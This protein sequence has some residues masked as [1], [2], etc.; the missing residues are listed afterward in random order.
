[1]RK[2]FYALS[3]SMLVLAIAAPVNTLAGGPVKGLP[4]GGVSQPASEAKKEFVP[5]QTKTYSAH[6]FTGPL[7]RV[8]SSGP[9]MAPAYSGADMPVI[10]GNVTF[11]SDEAFTTGAMYKVPMTLGGNFEYVGG[12]D[13]YANRGGV[14]VGDRYMAHTG[15]TNS[16]GALTTMYIRKL[17]TT[18]WDQKAKNSSVKVG[19]MATDLALDPTTDKVYG[20]FYND[21]QD[22]YVLGRMD[23]SAYKRI[24]IAELQRGWNAC[25]FDAQGQLYAIDMSGMLMKVDKETGDITNVGSTGVTPKYLTSACIDPVSGR[26]FWSV[27]PAD[28]SGRLY[29]V[30]LATGAATLL[31]RF[32]GDEDVVGMYIPTP[33][34]QDKAPARVDNLKAEFVN[35]ALTGNITFDAPTTA[36]DGS[37]L[38]GELTYT[39]LN[40][41]SKI[42]EGTTTCGAPTSVPVTIE[43]AA[44]CEFYVTVANAVGSSPKSRVLMYVGKDKPVKPEVSAV[45]ADG[46]F[47]VSWNPVTEGVN[48]GYMNADAVTYKV[49]R[50]PDKTVVA[51]ATAETSLIDEVAASDA[52]YIPYYYTVT[53][54]SEGV[55]SD[56]GQSNSI[57]LGQMVPPYSETFPNA[58]A[59]STFTIIDGNND[60]KVWTYNLGKA[61]I[62]ENATLNM[63][64]WLITPPI[65]LEK[66]KIYKFSM[67]LTTA[68]SYTECFEV[69]YGKGNTVADMT[70]VL[71]E[72]QEINAGDGRKFSAYVKADT[73]GLYYIGIHGMTK[74]NQFYIDVDNLMLEEGTTALIPEAPTKL[75]VAP[76]QNGALVADIT[77]NAPAKNLLGN[78]IE[79]LDKVEILR[80]GTVIDTKNQPAAGA[81]VSF[82][83]E[84]APAGKHIYAVVGY[85]EH[86]RGWEA[87]D[88]AYVGINVPAAATKVTAKETANVGEVTVT[89]QT[90]TT[91]VD[92]FAINP[93]LIKYD[94]VSVCGETTA[95]VA[96][97]LTANTYTYRVVDADTPQQFYYFQVNAKTSTGGTPALSASIPVGKADAVPYFESFADGATSHAIDGAPVVGDTSWALYTDT[98]SLGVTSADNDNGFAA[99]SGEHGNDAAAL[100]TGKID[101]TGLTN[102]VLTF[103]AYNIPSSDGALNDRNIIEVLVKE[104]GVEKSLG[105]FKM[106]EITDKAGWAKVL[107][108]LNKYAGKTV[109]LKWI[110]KIAS[111]KN[112]LIDNISVKE[113]LAYNLAA[114]AIDLPKKVLADTDFNVTVTVENAGSR[115]VEDYT[116]EL[117][118]D[119]KLI[120][121][122][123][124]V[125][126][127]PGAMATVVFTTSVGTVSPESV[128]YHAVVKYDTDMDTSDNVSKKASA[129]VK[130]PKYPVA[131]NLRGSLDEQKAAVLAWDKPETESAPVSVTEGFE[132]AESFAVNDVDEWTFIDLDE[133]RTYGIGNVS[134]P[135][136][137]SPMAYIVFDGTFEGLAGEPADYAHSGVKALASF[138]A[139]SKLNDDWA[140]SPRLCGIAQKIS[141]F[142]MSYH[143]DYIEKFE[144][145]YSTT[146]TA[147]E[148]FTKVGDTKEVPAQW[149]KYEFDVPEGSRYF[150]IRCVSPDRFIFLVDDVTFIPATPGDG[151]TLQGYNVYRDGVKIN[152]S[153][154]AEPTFTDATAENGLHTYVVTAVYDKGESAPSNSVDLTTS[155]IGNIEMSGAMVSVDGRTIVINGAEG[156][157]VSILT[158]DGKVIYRESPAAQTVRYDASQGIYIVTVGSHAEKVIVK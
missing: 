25:A 30:N 140:I 120:A 122:K 33:L 123:P 77:F 146:G 153:T 107:V 23:Y 80:D 34:A 101:L 24:I 96:E 136:S 21:A 10:Y 1:M 37:E 83:D 126:V 98:N 156:V 125:A 38:T 100:F 7:T 18:F 152:D 26:M 55:S 51:E 9:V 131:T 115:K 45:Y 35:G 138:A 158:V 2:H 44:K 110:S 90:P 48:G 97:N 20:C 132:S 14:E 40:K 13:I 151:L 61:R 143:S 43:K 87:V 145:Y 141:F 93:E 15:E 124:G 109:Q 76:D 86:G 50:Y 16:F 19:T 54:T 46:K 74:K 95:V 60:G 4:A 149:T 49:T 64:D 148:N 121:T 113:Y 31:C 117:Y 73:D 67:D 130:M 92:G 129:T 57:G 104:G 71:I 139:A 66:D 5:M 32:A 133:S 12:E 8:Y 28:E 108:Q 69:R 94:L 154:I 11:S 103:F 127:E 81:A 58:A 52:E 128:S 3:L 144:F 118:R 91:D 68:K 114:Y 135:N 155:G 105:E 70:N 78:A 119:D 111:F 102:P 22:G 89:W 75:A 112:T 17:D 106:N 84:T 88:S 72:V 79:S 39:V 116:V 36:F 62:R 27:C 147:I 157:D 142:A 59:L 53:A 41:T 82:K 137:N 134:F 85:N 65:R 47:T 150:A 63:N 99:S 29:E 42:A 6:K 56:A